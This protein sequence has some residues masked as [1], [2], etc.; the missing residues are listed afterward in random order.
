MKKMKNG[1]IPACLLLVALLLGGC[2][3]EGELT[4]NPPGRNVTVSTEA[5]LSK[6]GQLEGRNG[7]RASGTAELLLD[8]GVYKL[9]FTNLNVS[10][11]PDLRVY[12]S[13]GTSPQDKAGFPMGRPSW[14]TPCPK[15]ETLAPTPSYWSTARPSVSHLL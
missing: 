10:N 1:L 3:K 9:R 12:L 8:E 13:R 6:T 14:P 15:E 5:Q 11:G 4:R 7:Y 2:E